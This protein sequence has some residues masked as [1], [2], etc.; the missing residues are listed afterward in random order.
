MPR[1]KRAGE[2]SHRSS[3]HIASDLASRAPT[4]QA[5]TPARVRN[6]GISH[7]SWN[8]RRYFASQANIAR[9]FAG[10]V[11]TFFLRFQSERR[12]CRI[13][14]E[15]YWSPP[16]KQKVGVKTFWVW[17]SEIGEEC[18]QCWAWILA[19]I[20]LGGELKSWKTRPTNSQRNFAIK[21]HWE[22]RRQFSSNSPDQ[23]KNSPQIRFTEPRA[24]R[25]TFSHR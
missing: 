22:I 20:F 12:G 13:A 3:T 11:V 5:K 17:E 15:T 1:A 18:R 21:I 4:S 16:R 23:N 25:N 2:R 10:A 8:A 24:Q 6:A 7:R 19:W 9:L 14:S